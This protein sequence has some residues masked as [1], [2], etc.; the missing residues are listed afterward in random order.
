MN[1]I[2]IFRK[3]IRKN[4]FFKFFLNILYTKKNLYINFLIKFIYN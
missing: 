1:Y 2:I 3:K 4:E